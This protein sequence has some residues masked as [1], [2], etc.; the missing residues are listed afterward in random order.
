MNN[1]SIWA[2]Q[3]VKMERYVLGHHAFN[4]I[5]QIIIQNINKKLLNYESIFRQIV[6]IKL[7]NINDNYE[8]KMPETQEQDTEAVAYL[9]F[10]LNCNNLQAIYELDETMLGGEAITCLPYLFTSEVEN[11]ILHMDFSRNR[12]REMVKLFVIQYYPFMQTK[13]NW[14]EK[15]NSRSQVPKLNNDQT[16]TYFNITGFQN[17]CG[18]NW[19]DDAK[20]SFDETK[21]LNSKR[22]RSPKS[23]SDISMA[24][25]SKQSIE[26]NMDKECQTDPVIVMTQDQ[27]DQ[28]FKNAKE[29][30]NKSIR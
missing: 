3:L 22:K 14:F 25:T 9:S 11:L 29:F 12:Q 26:I 18:H 23:E 6:A 7:N 17:N 16:N 20:L 21:Y 28:L 4:F 19:N 13:S 8:L 5:R 27:I 15:F 30:L 10:R 24:K 2:Q 1:H